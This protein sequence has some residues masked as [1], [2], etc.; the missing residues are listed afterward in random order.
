MIELRGVTKYYQHVPAVVALD[1]NVKRGEIVG[2]IGHNGAGKTTTLKMILGLISPTGGEVRVMGHD[3]THDSARVK[4]FVGYLPE[5]SSLYET[6]TVTEY[7]LFFAEL[8]RIPKREALAR[9]ETLLSSLDLAERNRFTGELSKGMKRKVAIARA[10]LHDPPI[11][12]LD[13]PSSGLDPLTSIFII[14]YLR[15]LK[16]EG[17]TILMSAHNL[18]HVEHLCDRVAIMKSGR[19]LVYDDMQT[20][21]RK[22]GKSEYEVVFYA[23]VPLDYPREAGNYVFRTTSLSQ[24]AALLGHISENGWALV[25]LAVRESA[26]EEIYVQ[27]MGA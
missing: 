7:L 24:L 22:L 26:L 6:M 12:I 3:M 9:I 2:I 23:D 18:F 15:R 27:L 10:L 13:E 20:I 25:N 11:L 5:E 8:Y 17:K 1:L 16:E 14:N 4:R 19:L 21:R